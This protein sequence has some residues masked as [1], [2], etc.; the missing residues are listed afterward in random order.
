[1]HHMVSA[2][3]NHLTVT[4]PFED[5]TVT[6]RKQCLAFKRRPFRLPV[7]LLPI[8]SV[9]P[10]VVG[11]KSNTLHRSAQPLLHNVFIC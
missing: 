8:E 4:L 1:M 7:Y 9:E 10:A 11:V 5:A 6:D 3:R 2:V